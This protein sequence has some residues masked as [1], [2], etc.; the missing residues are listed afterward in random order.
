MY[1]QQQPNPRICHQTM[2]DKTADKPWGDFS[3]EAALRSKFNVASEDD[4]AAIDY[5]VGTYEHLESA[6][7][8]PGQK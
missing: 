8:E 4:L 5:Y 1:L 3:S 6:K 2:G 7:N